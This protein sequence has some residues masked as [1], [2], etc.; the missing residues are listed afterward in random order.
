MAVT[1]KTPLDT[2][3]FS[4][5]FP[6]LALS[7][8]DNNEAEVILRSPDHEIFSAVH[9]PYNWGIVIYD[10]RSVL[11]MY[12]RD[13]NLTLDEFELLA[14]HNGSQQILATFKIV[15]L[16]H[17]FSGDIAEFPR[18]ICPHWAAFILLDATETKSIWPCTNGGMVLT[19]SFKHHLKQRLR[20]GFYTFQWKSDEKTLN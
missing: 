2:L 5:S 16:E 20:G 1:L 8:S 7:T 6:D 17:S 4:S 13:R 19:I 12:M 11:E 9:F 18:S 14:V 3:M 15:Y 10:L